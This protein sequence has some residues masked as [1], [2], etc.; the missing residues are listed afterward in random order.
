MQNCFDHIKHGVHFRTCFVHIIK[1]VCQ[2]HNYFCPYLKRCCQHQKYPYHFGPYQQNFTYQ[3]MFCPYQ[4]FV[5]IKCCLC[6]SKK[7]FVHIETFCPY[8]K[9]NISKN[10]HSM[11]IHINNIFDHTKKGICP[12]KKCPY[13]SKYFCQFP[14]ILSI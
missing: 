9:K 12:C 2:Y 8:Q 13:Q 7:W 14:E 11:N 4:F 6:I 5:H 1:I 10:V 3:Q